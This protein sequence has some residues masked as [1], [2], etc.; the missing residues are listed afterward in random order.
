[1]KLYLEI[2]DA[3]RNLSANVL[4]TSIKYLLIEFNVVILEQDVLSKLNA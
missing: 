3:V 4:P 1:M 2:Y